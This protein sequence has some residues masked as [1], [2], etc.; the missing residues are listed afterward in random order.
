MS[1]LPDH[2][3]HLA[4]HGG[5]YLRVRGQVMRCVERLLSGAL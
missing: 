5:R 4:G 1:T 3:M 2:R